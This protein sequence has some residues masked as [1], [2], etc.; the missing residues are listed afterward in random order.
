MRGLKSRASVFVGSGDE[1]VGDD[2][3]LGRTEVGGRRV[4][5][6]GSDVS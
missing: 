3:I 1:A 2:A 5:L 4:S 6:V